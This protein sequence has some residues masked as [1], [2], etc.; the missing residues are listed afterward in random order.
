MFTFDASTVTSRVGVSFISTAQACSNVNSQ[1]PAGTNQTTLAAQT[2][3]AWNDQ[4]LS[5]ITTTDSAN[6]TRLQLLYSSMYHMLLLPQNK[7]GE[8]P[9]WTSTE[10]YYDDIFTLWDLVAALALYFSYVLRL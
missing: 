3:A 1:V 6:T 2:R 7:T 8:N 5:K 4:V 9:L 10:P